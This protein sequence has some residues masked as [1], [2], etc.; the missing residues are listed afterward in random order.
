[1]DAIQE[2]KHV[3]LDRAGARASVVSAVMLFGLSKGISPQEMKQATGVSLEALVDP[4]GRLPDQVM[5]QAWKLIGERFPGQ[6]IALEMATAAP[7]SV[8]GPLAQAAR[9]SPTRGA[10]L[11]LFS[12]Y[13][14]VLSG[15]LHMSIVR[16]GPS[17][18]LVLEHQMDAVDGGHG[19]EA[20]VGLGSRIARDLFGIQDSVVEIEFAHPPNAPEAVYHEWFGAPVRFGCGRNAMVF[21]S[22]ELQKTPAQTNPQMYAFIETHLALVEKG[23]L[24]NIREEPLDRVRVQLA[25]QAHRSDY[26]AESLAQKTGMSVRTLQRFTAKHGVSLRSMIEE[27]REANARRLLSDARLSVDEVAFL[28]GYSDD[29]A[30]RRAFKRWTGTTP[31]A[32]RTQD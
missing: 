14:K 4:E 31:A 29:R 12:R 15:G 20:A 27:V 17:T 6:A 30:F 22:E 1:M 32:F 26:S 7:M 21:D 16:S 23:L 18:A 11:S 2:T 19:A 3:K 5:A 24:A 13:D 10:M 8:F 28:L 25:A 9:F